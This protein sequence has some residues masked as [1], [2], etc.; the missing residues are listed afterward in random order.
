MPVGEKHT[1]KTTVNWIVDEGIIDSSTIVGDF[2]SAVRKSG[3]N[4]HL[5]KY[6]PFSQDQ[7]YGG[8]TQD[9]CCILYGNH[10]YIS[11]CR[12][13]F[14]PGAYGINENTNVQ[15]YYTQVPLYNLLNGMTFQILPFGVVKQRLRDILEQY[16]GKFFMRPISGFKTFPGQV[17]DHETVDFEFNSTQQLSSVMDSTLCLLAPVQKLKAEYRFVIA[18]HEVIGGSQYRRDDTL[19]IRRDYSMEALSM[20]KLMSQLEWQPDIVYTCDVADTA[21]GPYIIELNS[22]ACAGLYACDLDVIVDRVN[23]VALMEYNGEL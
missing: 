3:A 19:D 23:T 6:I 14:I 5:A 9:D 12:M 16:G 20:A 7:D 15:H 8:F 4:L 21:E 10:N 22:F 18:N 11:R 13:G 1:M 2:R 17:F